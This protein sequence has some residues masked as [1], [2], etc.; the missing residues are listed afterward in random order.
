VLP[1]LL[2]VVV[3]DTR[4]FGSLDLRLILVFTSSRFS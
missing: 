4:L 3:L 1:L 2:L